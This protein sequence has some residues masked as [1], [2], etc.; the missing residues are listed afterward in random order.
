MTN[1]SRA[2]SAVSLVASPADGRLMLSRKA[3]ALF[4]SLSGPVMAVN[5]ARHRLRSAPRGVARAHLGPGQNNYIDGWINC[6]ANIFTGKA[7]R[8][9]DLRNPLPFPDNSLDAVYSHHVVEHLPDMDAHFRDVL[10][11]LKP[12]GVYRVGGPDADVAIARYQAGDLDWFGVW[13]DKRRTS[14]G[15]LNN[16]L[17]CRGEHVAL[18]TEDFLR[19]LLEDAGFSSIQRSA[20]RQSNHPALFAD[21]FP[22][23]E[24]SPPHPMTVLLEVM[25]S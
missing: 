20:P 22:F 19:E 4:Y 23:E 24:D 14:G 21:V 15:R 12:G 2:N 16:F 10:R 11:V 7:D 9:I 18:L 3:K 13:P 17:F 8:W 6:D 1:V 25:K 5:G